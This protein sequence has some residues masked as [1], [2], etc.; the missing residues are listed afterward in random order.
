MIQDIAPKVF[1]N[2][3]ENLQPGSNASVLV[4]K[5]RKCL[6]WRGKY[7]DISFP[8]AKDCGEGFSY[9]YLFRIDDEEYYQGR[10]ENQSDLD[11]LCKKKGSEW[12]EPQSFRLGEPRDRCFAGI[13]G[14]QLYNWYRRHRYCGH[15]GSETRHSEEER[16][17]MCPECG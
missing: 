17:V 10:T 1:H 9:T 12:I 8:S 4:F 5:D 2:E 13:T 15:C 11:R 6:I 7:G 14:F 3:F 16:M